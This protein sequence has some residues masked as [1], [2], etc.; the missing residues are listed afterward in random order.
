MNF[1]ILVIFC[2][3]LFWYLFIGVAFHALLTFWFHDFYNDE[4]VKYARHRPEWAPKDAFLIDI[5]THT[6]ASDGVLTPGQLVEW[7]ISNGYDGVVV[8][9]HNTM[10]S[11]VPCQEYAAKHHPEFVVI[12]GIEFT[13]MRVHLNLIGNKTSMKTPRMLWTTKKTMKAAINHAHSEGGVVQ[14]N[15]RAWYPH[16][17]YPS[18]EWFLENGI[19]GWE[20]YNGYRPGM[21]DNESPRFIRENQDKKMYESAGTDVHD[22][23]K[24]MRV[25]TEILTDDRTVEGVI[26]TLK[27]GKTRVYC[28]MESERK[29]TRPEKGK[30][31]QS[32]EKL[33]FKKRWAIFYNM[34]LGLVFLVSM[35]ALG[36]ILSLLL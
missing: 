18:N 27:E 15:H 19:D 12:P 16:K 31:Q 36:V 23:A 29:R 28:D 20:I 32:P 22:P 33:K 3:G 14:F 30:L 34:K 6:V 7:E 25:Y 10:G 4:D 21:I 26:K 13:S 9:D 5:H 1:W 11:V 8:S 24:E 35:L 17:K 2:I